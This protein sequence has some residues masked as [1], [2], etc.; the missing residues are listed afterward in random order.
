[1][2]LVNLDLNLLLGL[3]ALLQERSV[4]RAANKLGLSQPALSASLA[5][6][7]RHFDDELL[8]RV[9]N[10]YQLTP[11]ALQLRPRT[12]LA[13][14]GVERVFESQAAFEPAQS[15]REFVVLASD[16]AIAV[17]GETL[18]DV[19]TEQAPL[20]RV[21]F[22]QLQTAIIERA[23]ESL[24][25]L[26]GLLLPHGFMSDVSHIDLYEDEYVFLVATD[27]PK[28]GA[29]LTMDNLAELP[30]VLTYHGPSSF[31]PASR[32][33]QMLGVEPH[34]QLVVESF[35]ALPFLVAHSERIA[36]VQAKLTD[37]F[38]ASGDVRAMACPFDA[39]PLVGAFWWHPIHDGDLEHEWLRGALAEAGRRV[40]QP[41]QAPSAP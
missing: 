23:P 13:L 17:V 6:L 11:L 21:R 27:N 41:G 8:T 37:R 19:L 15:R 10:S 30:W 2:R 26:D 40:S 12:S 24:R 39:V 3:D 33:L 18:C 38:T 25:T 22:R 29:E 9:G 7:R 20:V 34:V 5:R 1:V 31:T 35:L 4:T 32:Q 14:A 16:Y 36:L 28:V